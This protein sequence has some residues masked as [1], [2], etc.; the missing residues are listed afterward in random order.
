MSNCKEQKIVENIE[1]IS[2]TTIIIVPYVNGPNTQ[3]TQIVLVYIKEYKTT[4][5]IITV[6]RKSTLSRKI[7]QE[8]SKAKKKD[9]FY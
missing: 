8:K 1:Y 3:K 2:K 4:K 7:Q 5:P 9:T 6:N